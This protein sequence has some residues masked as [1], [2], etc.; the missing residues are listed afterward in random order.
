LKRVPGVRDAFVIAH[1]ERADALA[2]AVNTE[3]QAEVIRSSLRERLAVWKIPKKIVTVSN[4]PLTARG[5][6]DTARLR[7]L[8]E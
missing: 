7:Q 3:L 1:A 2:A 4:F 8:I 6:T 5:K